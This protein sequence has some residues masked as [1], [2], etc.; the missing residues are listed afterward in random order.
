[1]SV[2]DTTGKARQRRR[3]LVTGGAGFIGSHTADALLTRGDDVVIMDN[4][5]TYYDKSVKRANVQLLQT[6]YGKDRCQFVEA[7]IC[8]QN[9]I[10]NIFQSETLKPDAVCHLAA[11]AGVRP[12]IVDPILY[13]RVNIEGTVRIFEAARQHGVN[14]V[15][16]ASSSSVYGGSKKTFFRETDREDMM[17]VSQYAA[18]KKTTELMAHTYY[19]LYGLNVTGLR[20]FTVYGPRGRPDM[21]ALKFIERIWEGIPIDRYGDGSSER[22]WTFVSDIVSGI[23][24]A[25]DRPLGY[26]VFNLGNGNPIKLND[27]I[28]VAHK[29]IQRAAGRPLK[30]TINQLP[31][32]P[33]DVPRTCADVSHAQELLGYS[34]QV[35]LKDGLRKT[36]DWFVAA[37]QSAA[38][39]E[40]E[41]ETAKEREEK[42]HSTNSSAMMLP[43]SKAES[44]LCTVTQFGAE[45]LGL[46]YSAAKVEDE[47]T[48]ASDTIEMKQPESK[49]SLEMPIHGLMVGTRIYRT[50]SAAAA[51][52]ALDDPSSA[53]DLQRLSA[54]LDSAADFAPHIAVAVDASGAGG[55]ELLSQVRRLCRKKQKYIAKHCTVA[56]VPLMQWGRITPA[57][58][59]LVC[60]ASA[61]NCT[62]LL[63]QS[64]E[65]RVTAAAACQLVSHLEPGTLVVGACFDG[66]HR[67]VGESKQPLG[68]M[69]CPWNTAAVWDV[70]RLSL[71]GFLLVSELDP[72]S[73]GMEEV[74]VV[75]LHQH[76][77][78]QKSAAKLVQM[79][80]SANFKWEGMSAAKDGACRLAYHSKKMESKT[81]RAESQLGLLQGTG[82]CTK[83]SVVEHIIVDL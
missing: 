75:A 66:L 5:N 42:A 81:E 58:N 17:P 41:E 1:M 64:L 14:H 36:V 21:A 12:S 15:V 59:A 44:K 63:L 76:A 70:N 80:H 43:E 22:D 30:L 77:W 69:S 60:K 72:T 11:R 62:R 20:F 2:T 61:V 65:V 50:E 48:G 37:K 56:V 31:D 34:P 29:E 19:H 23:V 28:T 73:A 40:C 3:F 6:K 78:P 83:G 54:M 57:L 18:T 39:M 45:T 26:E 53:A 35:K 46:D 24:R 38:E 71:T 51:A 8:D 16:Y 74:A 79:P 10:D 13:V 52:A 9:A 33:G 82:M 27:F 67:F 32:Q 47:E 55:Q 7:D 4:L 68:A 49:H 25:L